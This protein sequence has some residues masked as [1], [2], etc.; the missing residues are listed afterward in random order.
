MSNVSL[1]WALSLTPHKTNASK[2]AFYDDPSSSSSDSDP[3]DDHGYTWDEVEP[4]AE[5]GAELEADLRARL[6]EMAEELAVAPALLAGDRV[7]WTK[8]SKNIPEG[9]VG[10]I[11]GPS[12]QY[13][14]E[15]E[16][17]F[18]KGEWYLPSAQ[19][20][21]QDERRSAAQVQEILA[22]LAK[23]PVP[24]LTTL[25]PCSKD[26]GHALGKLL[27]ALGDAKMLI[28]STP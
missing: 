23:P 4:A 14:G 6:A 19:L 25:Q 13:P 20:R 28:V 22:R 5:S 18:P 1:L 24:A 3:F 16:V 7:T 26:F 12:E 27:P 11:Q 21:R 10:V 15:L 8:S 9:H 17:K 2:V